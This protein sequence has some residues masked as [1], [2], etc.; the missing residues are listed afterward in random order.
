MLSVGVVGLGFGAN[1]ARV[2][3]GLEGVRLAAICDKDK[4]RLAAIPVTAG[5]T[6]Y[7]DVEEMLRSQRLQAVVVAVP[8]FLHE[9]VAMSAIGAGCSVLVEKPLALSLEA[10]RRVARAA[11]DAGVVLM[12]GHIERFNAALREVVRRVRAGDVG[13]VL[14]V[15]A[16]RLAYFTDR[17]RTMDVGV[18]PDLALHDVDAIS[19]LVGAPVERVFAEVHT[20]V[21][22]PYDDGVVALIRFEG[23]GSNAGVL[24]KLE[25]NRL[26]PRKVRELVVLGDKGQLTASYDDFR[27][28]TV[29]FRAAQALKAL[30][31]AP[32][33]ESAAVRVSGAEPGAPVV[34]AVEPREPLVEELRAF[35]AAV[36]H[37]TAPP[38]TPDDGLRALA[39]VDALLESARTGQAVRPERI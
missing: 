17:A 27:S 11:A 4:G 22:T 13:R 36:R 1:H 25:V 37:G 30:D 6:R 14:Q 35:V 8:A 21:R 32:M 33:G 38:V 2:L 18:I 39:I 29:E 24:A 23:D 28:A 19:W 12:P 10:G 20:G 16:R 9:G 26:S 5:V 15:S 3:A 7:A 34:T 31:G